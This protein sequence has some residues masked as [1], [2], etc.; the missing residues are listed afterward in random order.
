MSSLDSLVDAVR[1]RVAG[2]GFELVDLKRGGGSRRPFL[3]IRIDRPD[4]ELGRGVTAEDC[5]LVSRALE[6]WL[7]GEGGFGPRYVLQV[8]SPGIERPVRWP[9]HWRRFVGRE[10]RLR[11]RRLPGQLR[12]TIVGVPDDGH[13]AVRLA[14]G[15]ELVLALADV[16]DATLVVD[17]N[18]L[19]KP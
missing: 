17:W 14:S 8:S 9:E 5:A 2:F 1:R 19:G 13:V 12:A 4:A 3:Q 11:S 15:E 10:V 7:E 18:R 16:R 6:R